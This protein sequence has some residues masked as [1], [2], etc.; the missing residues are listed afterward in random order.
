MIKTT[1]LLFGT[2]MV[3]GIGIRAGS[4]LYSYIK[5]KVVFYKAGKALVKLGLDKLREQDP[6]KD[7]FRS[8]E[9]VELAK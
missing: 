1:V 8:L 9:L 2:A 6:V 4:D 7:T 3:M 5:K